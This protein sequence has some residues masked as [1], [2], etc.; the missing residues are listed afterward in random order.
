MS[1]GYSKPSNTSE[2]VNIWKSLINF[3]KK[4]MLEIWVGCILVFGCSLCLQTI[5]S[6]WKKQKTTTTT[7]TKPNKKQTTTTTTTTKKPHRAFTY[8]FCYLIYH[9]LLQ[10]NSWIHR[11][12]IFKIFRD[13]YNT[14]GLAIILE[15]FSSKNVCFSD[16]IN[17]KAFY[18]DVLHKYWDF[19]QKDQY[20]DSIFAMSQEVYLWRYILK[21]VQWNHF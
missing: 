2:I 20:W 8:Y 5:G 7:T 13:S 12:K 9:N 15:S 14:L 3:A 16:A 18:F 1:E 10:T 17:F 19:L 21:V 4:S 11:I 6:S